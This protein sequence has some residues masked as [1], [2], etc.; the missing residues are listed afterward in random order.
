MAL[1]REAI[2]KLRAEMRDAKNHYKIISKG[3]STTAVYQMKYI[4]HGD[5]NYMS[6][7]DLILQII[8]DKYKITD[9]EWSCLL[10]LYEKD[11][12]KRSDI[13]QF[14]GKG[15]GIRS[16][17]SFVQK[18]ERLDFI[19]VEV[20][21]SRINSKWYAFTTAFK[22]VA[23]DFYSKINKISIIPPNSTYLPSD[24][25]ED[26]DLMW[27]VNEFNKSV[28]FHKKEIKR[29]KERMEREDN[30]EICKNTYGLVRKHRI[31]R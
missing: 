10:W 24:Y 7:F 5:Y 17:D 26:K 19:K 21:N 3:V 2:R 29:K 23:L 28:R 27:K 8:N 22:R 1:N 15:Y 18:L 4:I 14:M 31:R 25:L 30:G 9:K 12:F 20:N 6:F 13:Q 16:L 11:M